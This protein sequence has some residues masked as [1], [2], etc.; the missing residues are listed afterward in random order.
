MADL[1]REVNMKTN[2]IRFKKLLTICSLMLVFITFISG[3]STAAIGPPGMKLVS[4]SY[5]LNNKIDISGILSVLENR[6][7]DRKLLERTKEK[8]SSLDN[9]DIR[10]IASLCQQISRGNNTPGSDIA[11]S[12][13]SA[14]IILS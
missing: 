8:L 12:L 5:S 11:F 14:L 7:K 13:V 9:K 1:L 3:S 2:I 4:L 6:V 10:L